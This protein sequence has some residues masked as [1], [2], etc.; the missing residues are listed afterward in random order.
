MLHV[1]YCCC[2]KS[3]LALIKF[4]EDIE[5]VTKLLPQF[6]GVLLDLK[7]WCLSIFQLPL[8]V[9]ALDNFIYYFH[10]IIILTFCFCLKS[11]FYHYHFAIFASKC[12]HF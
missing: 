6:L 10:F 5:V 8:N 12:I 4:H 3:I 7:Q 1:K 9:I 11:V 2:K